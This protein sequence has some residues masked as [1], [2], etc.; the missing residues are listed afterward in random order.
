MRHERRAHARRGT[1][2]GSSYARRTPPPRRIA[3]LALVILWAALK[4]FPEGLPIARPQPCLRGQGG[5]LSVPVGACVYPPARPGPRCA[6]RRTVGNDAANR[7]AL[8]IELQVHVLALGARA[9]HSATERARAQ[10]SGAPLSAPL[11]PPLSCCC[12]TACH[13]AS[14]RVCKQLVIPVKP[15]HQSAAAPHAGGC[16]RRARPA[17]GASPLRSQTSQTRAPSAAPPAP[18]ARATAGGGRSS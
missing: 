12:H 7:V 18:A 10:A 3:P 16:C 17:A 2:L 9:S 14:P 5:M 15:A 13:S 8:V 11:P 4:P 6:A 1:A